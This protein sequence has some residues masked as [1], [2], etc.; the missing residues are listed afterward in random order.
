MAT[1]LVPTNRCV[2][3]PDTCNGATKMFS[4]VSKCLELSR[5]FTPWWLHL[6]GIQADVQRTVRFPGLP[7]RS[8][9]SD[10]KAR[11][12]ERFLDGHKATRSMNCNKL[13]C[14]WFLRNG[15]R[16]KKTKHNSQREIKPLTSWDPATSS[17]RWIELSLSTSGSSTNSAKNVANEPKFMRVNK[18]CLHCLPQ[19]A[20]GSSDAA[21]SEWSCSSFPSSSHSPGH[22]LQSGRVGIP[23]NQWCLYNTI[24]TV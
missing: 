4:D 12:S 16:W 6:L 2:R 24:P 17:S 23:R 14:W 20:M 19:A 21:L 1:S 10:V 8:R 13:S 18:S 9:R 15:K 3:P 5:V 22:L 11:A 7:S